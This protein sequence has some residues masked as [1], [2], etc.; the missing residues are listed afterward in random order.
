[1]PSPHYD[2]NYVR[3]TEAAIAVPTRIC[4]VS[5][6]SPNGT[7]P[8]KRTQGSAD[9]RN[10]YVL[11]VPRNNSPNRGVGNTHFLLTLSFAIHTASQ[12]LILIFH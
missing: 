11:K 10:P 3:K 8:R 4:S 1:M 5:P 12:V 2:A 7:R 6:E 9:S